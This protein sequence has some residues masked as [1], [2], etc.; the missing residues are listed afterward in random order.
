MTVNSCYIEPAL[1]MSKANLLALVDSEKDLHIHFLQSLLQAPSPNPPGNTVAAARVVTNYLSHHNISF[2]ILSPKEDAPNVVSTLS[3]P[4]PSHG[5]K[6]VMNG[7][8]DVFPVSDSNDWAHD[9]W[10]GE[11]ANGKIYGRGVVDMK[12]GLA[13]LTIAYTY[14]HRFRAHLPNGTC[15]F[16]AVSDEETGGAFGTK[17]LLHTDKNRDIWRGTAVL[18]TEPSGLQSFRFGEKGTL[19]LTF[20][21]RSP[22][23]HG[24]FTHLDEGATHIAARLILRLTTSIEAFTDF[25]VDPEISAHLA[26][27]AVRATI[28]EIMGT[29]AAANMLKATV[30][31]GTINGGSKVNTIP[32]L[33]TF[34]ADIRLPIG[35]SATPILNLISDI[36]AN[37][38]PQ[39]EVAVQDAASNPS[40]F[41]SPSHPLAV[42]IADNAE[43]VLDRRPLGVPSLGATDVK[44]FRYLGVPGY[45][46]G[47]SPRGM[48][49]VDESVDLEEY[50]GLIKVIVGA[51]WDYLGGET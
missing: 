33:C 7:H 12:A 34:E 19:R 36:L 13:A 50:F 28:D 1:T 24:A 37:E 47:V 9:P 38:Y 48:A 51:A 21:V 39:V 23:G 20:T 49:G 6:L 29:G 35:L 8:L 11:I 18:N 14:I 16:E 25:E 4:D 17:Y 22:G 31:I 44:H 10:G 5:P 2:S 15:T 3:S 43:K 42:A 27:P 45:S 30:N 32:N 46:F 41:C 40:N 26:D